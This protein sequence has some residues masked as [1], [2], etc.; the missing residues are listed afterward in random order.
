MNGLITGHILNKTMLNHLR[1]NNMFKRVGRRVSYHCHMQ[2]V[3]GTKQ[4]QSGC[5]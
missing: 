4:K 1:E 3:D 5:L 2:G